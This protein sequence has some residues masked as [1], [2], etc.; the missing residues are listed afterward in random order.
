MC[1]EGERGGVTKTTKAPLCSRDG[2]CATDGSQ[3]RDSVAEAMAEAPDALSLKPGMDVIVETMVQD[4]AKD[5]VAV[6]VIK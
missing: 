2:Y 6:R 1:I 4:I 3:V 5:L